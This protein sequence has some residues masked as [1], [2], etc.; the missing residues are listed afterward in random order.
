MLVG[1]DGCQSTLARRNGRVEVREIGVAASHLGGE[2]LHRLMQRTNLSATLEDSA[3]VAARAPLHE[4]DP[5]KH[6]SGPRRHRNR[7]DPGQLLRRF[8][9]LGDQGAT[10]QPRHDR[11]VRAGHAHDAG[12]RARARRDDEG[13]L[14]PGL[15][16]RLFADDKAAPSGVALRE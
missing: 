10:N 11:S 6:F 15:A 8:E 4:P 12:Q 5:M 13:H 2:R 3:D 9:R 14:T 16:A 1:D 7:H